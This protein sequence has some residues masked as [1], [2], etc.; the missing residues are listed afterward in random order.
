MVGK[1]ARE[2]HRSLSNNPSAITCVVSS[3]VRALP[4]QGRSRGFESR[5]ARIMLNKRFRH[6]KGNEYVVIALGKDT[7]S[8]NDVVVYQALYGDNEVWVRPLEMFLDS[9]LVNGKIVDRFS[10]I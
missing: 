10:E 2:E 4:C 9:V 1:Q 6:F 5:T 8:M 7:E 3:A